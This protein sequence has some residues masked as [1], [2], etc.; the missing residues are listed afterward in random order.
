MQ[1]DIA[2][3]NYFAMSDDILLTSSNQAKFL[4]Q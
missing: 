3:C 2:D 4:Y 1:F